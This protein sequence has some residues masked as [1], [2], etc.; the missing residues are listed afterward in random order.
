MAAIIDLAMFCLVLFVVLPG[1]MIFA[2]LMR[3]IIYHKQ[4]RIHAGWHQDV[5]ERSTW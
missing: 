2:M 4:N 1:M 5:A 3:D